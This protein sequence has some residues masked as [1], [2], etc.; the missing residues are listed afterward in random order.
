VVTASLAPPDF[1]DLTRW[2]IRRGV[3]LLG[4]Q[5]AGLDRRALELIASNTNR[6]IGAGRPFPIATDYSDDDAGEVQQPEHIGYLARVY[7][8]DVSGQPHL[9]G[10]LAFERHRADEAQAY[11]HC[12]VELW[13]SEDPRR[14][15]VN[16]V[17]LLKQQPNRTLGPLRFSRGVPVGVT[18]LRYSRTFRNEDHMSNLRLVGGDSSTITLNRREYDELRAKVDRADRAAQELV[19]YERRRERRPILERLAADGYQFSV[20]E[21]VDE[22]AG[23]S[24]EKFAKEVH[25]IKTRYRRSEPLAGA[26][27]RYPSDDDAER[28]AVIDYATRHGITNLDDARAAYRRSLNAPNRGA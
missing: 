22:T 9:I 27:G 26:A 25:K 13:K 18:V 28:G 8:G 14:N 12:G 24:D 2:T 11:Q 15:V 7:V 17:V 3:A 4:A 5:Q 6:E 16:A 23:L 19:R 21:L 10:D 20:D 1:T